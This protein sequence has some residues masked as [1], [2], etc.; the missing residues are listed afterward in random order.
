MRYTNCILLGLF[1]TALLPFSIEIGGYGVT[2]NYLYVFFPFIFLLAGINRGVIFRKEIILIILFYTLIYFIGIPGD[3]LNTDSS[4]SRQSRRFA[5]FLVFIFPLFLSFIK[6]QPEDFKIFKL[7]IVLAALYVSIH[8]IITI[9]GIEPGSVSVFRYKGLVGSQRYGFILCL[10][11]IITLLTAKPSQGEK[12]FTGLKLIFCS[13]ILI[14]IFSTFSRSS[15]VALTGALIFL[16]V[17]KLL[18]KKHPRFRRSHSIE[19]KKKIV[20]FGET[21]LSHILLICALSGAVLLIFAN[22]YQIDYLT[23]YTNR[24]GD[25]IVTPLGNSN[26]IRYMETNPES[27]E[28]Y[29]YKIFQQVLE[30]LSVN[31]FFGS[32]Y[33]G[34]YLIFEDYHGVAS[35][36]NQYLDVF[37]RVGLPGGIL[38]LFLLVKIF[39]FCSHHDE[40]LLVGLVSILV[41]G[42][43]HETF[44]MSYGSFIFGMLLSFS[45]LRPSWRQNKL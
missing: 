36:H 40:G 41:Y 44:K 15:I 19:D 33:K 7:A 18:Q 16:I 23:F 8:T 1:F 13:V 5:S 17:L 31:P 11:L 6:F 9:Y 30:Y 4:L 39:R 38:W 35:T 27:S 24:I 34:L 3:I 25:A 42:I 37:L 12:K 22:S 21:R 26:M 43:V 2:A 10:G 20:S 29:R 14:G 28:G 32:N 45:Y